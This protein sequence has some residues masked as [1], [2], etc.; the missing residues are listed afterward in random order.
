MI[1]EKRQRRFRPRGAP[2]P[3]R[4]SVVGYLNTAPLVWG[5]ERGPARHRFQL[6]YTVPSSCAEA[7]RSSAADIG[8]IPVIEYQTIPGLR[9]IPRIAIASQRRVES[10]LLVS[11]GPARRAKRVALDESSRTSAA[12]VKVLFARQWRRE[13]EYVQAKPDLRVMLE[14]ADAGLV[15]GDPA[16]RF[17]LHA[18]QTQLPE[19]A[20][21]HV[22]DLGEE[23]WRLTSLPFVF[24]FWAVRAARAGS[25]RARRALVRAFLESRESG[26][27]HLEEIARAAASKLEVPG[28]QLGRY[29]RHSIDFRLDAPHRAGLECFYRYARDL[30]LIENLRPLE[31]L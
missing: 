13:P 16:L 1:K 20:N 21:L 4:V 26:L 11:R 15:I 31:F 29:L 3:L 14:A 9:V 18:P 17:A 19:N 7:L 5:L 2:K 24:A 25:A 22:Y 10:V 8:I 30:G 28:G 27:A 23:W 12:L 6:S